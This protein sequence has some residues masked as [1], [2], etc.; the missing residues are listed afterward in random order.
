MT[1]HKAAENLVKT[2]CMY[3]SGTIATAPEEDRSGW[4]LFVE[5]DTDSFDGS[6]EDRPPRKYAFV[7]VKSTASG[8]TGDK[9]K[10]SNV[11]EACVS[12]APWFL[13]KVM[14]DRSLR[15]IH[16]WGPVLNK[17]LE[18]IREASVN[19]KP[20]HSTKVS[21]NFGRKTELKKNPAEWMLAEI[22]LVGPNYEL[23]KAEAVNAAGYKDGYGKGIISLHDT[24]QDSWANVFLGIS[25]GAKADFSFTKTRF[26]LADPQP[27]VDSKSGSVTISPTPIGQCSFRLRG[28]SNEPSHSVSGDVYGYRHPG[29]S[30]PYLR[31]SAPPLEVI[32]NPDA[33]AIFRMTISD[34]EI[35]YPLINWY[36]YERVTKWSEIGEI[37]LE[38]TTQGKVIS[39]S[40]IKIDPPNSSND[41]AVLSNGISAL[42]R[43]LL[44]APTT[45][46]PLSL[47]DF[48]KASEDLVAFAS[49]LH[50]HSLKLEFGQ[51][52][53]YPAPFGSAI[54]RVTIAF[55]K[56]LLCCFVSRPVINDEISETRR[57][58]LGSPVV[59][60]L[61]A[62]PD[63]DA[64]H[65]ELVLS[66]YL[67]YANSIAELEE[68]LD[69][70]DFNAALR[71]Q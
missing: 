24:D 30:E 7:Q 28:L 57:V 15:G 38:I 70:Q 44:V 60:E 12:R 62:Y 58:T 20:L 43:A 67:T 16:V 45:I 25:T 11:Q 35:P 2:E 49:G 5:F 40:K 41:V 65:Y 27:V 54:Y 19:G 64:S 26:G 69:L 13:I 51:D 22:E 53:V 59:R 31:F 66:H 71:G 14:K 36:S 55:Q 68:A 1:K 17:W 52:K 42:R 46:P 48:S 39:T 63:P 33:G 23:A 10:L 50:E 37:D 56:L 21:V 3:F 9:I 8:N 47:N 34:P 4:D 6:A 32:R 18:A 61:F 29:S